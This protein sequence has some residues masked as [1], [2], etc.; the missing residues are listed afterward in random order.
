MRHIKYKWLFLSI[1][2]VILFIST[3]MYCILWNSFQTNTSQYYKTAGPQ[4]YNLTIITQKQQFT[5]SS[6]I[7]QFLAKKK[8]DE[9]FT[10]PIDNL[11]IIAVPFNANHKSINDTVIFRIKETGN[12]NWYFQSEYKT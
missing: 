8:N 4:Q 11:G 10:S 12:R 5:N 3:C 6:Y 7:P 1:S 9:T 2:S